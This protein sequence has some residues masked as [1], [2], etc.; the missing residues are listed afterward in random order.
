MSTIETWNE[1]L[2]AVRQLTGLDA[3]IA[4]GAVRDHQLA[5][6]PKD[7]DVFV[8]SAPNGHGML[9]EPFRYLEPNDARASEYEGKQWVKYVYDYDLR[10]HAVQLIE[11]NIPA[12]PTFGEQLVSSF[13]IG[14]TRCW[15]DGQIHEMPEFV[16]DAAAGCQTILITDRLERSIARAERFSQRHGGRYPHVV[17]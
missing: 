11:V 16:A 14:L 13:D 4:G 7:I 15:Y 6:S 9:P 12:G 8:Q 17:A 10:G 5:V 2:D 3:V 1:I